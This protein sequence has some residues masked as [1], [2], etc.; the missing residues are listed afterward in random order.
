MKINYDDAGQMKRKNKLSPLSDLNGCF[1]ESDLLFYY[2]LIDHITG[3]LSLI[4]MTWHIYDIILK[5]GI[6]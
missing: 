2:L 6:S 5:D 1:I 3:L 4:I